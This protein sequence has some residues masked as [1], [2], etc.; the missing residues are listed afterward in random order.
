MGKKNSHFK[1]K[2]LILPRL[3]IITVS[4]TR[5]KNN[6]IF[7]LFKIRWL[8]AARNKTAFFLRFIFPIIYLMLTL[9]LQKFIA[10]SPSDDKN[11][12]F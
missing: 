5:K 6:G 12:I 7:A 3:V 2:N 9:L 1:F 11:V 8:I 4:R 10:N